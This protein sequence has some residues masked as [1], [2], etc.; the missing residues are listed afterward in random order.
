MGMEKELERRRTFASSS[1]LLLMTWRFLPT[2]CP[3]CINNDVA[4][5]HTLANLV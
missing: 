4:K 1:G 5:G 2:E 3:L